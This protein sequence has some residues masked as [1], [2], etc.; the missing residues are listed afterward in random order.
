[1]PNAPPS[2]VKRTRFSPFVK[3][4]R[5]YQQQGF[6]QLKFRTHWNT[7]ATS[8]VKN[9]FVMVDLR[10][11]SIGT[12]MTVLE[13]INT[14]EP[15]GS[16]TS[17]P[18]ITNALSKGYFGIKTPCIPLVSAFLCGYYRLEMVVLLSSD[19]DVIFGR[20]WNHQPPMLKNT[21]SSDNKLSRSDEDFYSCSLVCVIQ[22]VAG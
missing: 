1:M 13:R 4:G 16:S 5:P 7:V 14:G 8:L 15:F 22:G 10:L 18:T 11:E 2:P 19:T 21:E 12:N 3:H 6:R 17:R 20:K 9:V